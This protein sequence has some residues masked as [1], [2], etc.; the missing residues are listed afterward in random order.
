MRR[1]IIIIAI[2]FWTLFAHAQKSIFFCPYLTAAPSG[3]LYDSTAGFTSWAASH[4]SFT[5][6]QVNAPDCTRNGVQ[7]TEDSTASVSHYFQ[8]TLTTSI[9][10]ASHTFTLYAARTIGTRNVE[11]TVY[12]SAYSQSAYVGANP[13]T[14]ANSGLAATVTGTY[15]SPSATYTAVSSAWCKIA[16]TFTVATSDT[17]VVLITD[18]TSAALPSYSGDGASSLGI[19]GVD[20]R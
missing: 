3:G 14:C 6:Y 11:L 4:A 13:T 12:S 16:L 5:A 19:W 15:T 8:Y 20:F 18:L 10:A 7:L 17:G 9:T 1:L 2:L